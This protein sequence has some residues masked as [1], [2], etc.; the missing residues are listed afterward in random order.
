MPAHLNQ[1]A[2]RAL[3]C[4]A[5]TLAACTSGEK[6]AERSAL[7]QDT[8]SAAAVTQAVTPETAAALDTAPAATPAMEAPAGDVAAGGQE[9]K[10]SGVIAEVTELRRRG[11]AVSAKLRFSNRGSKTAQ[12]EISYK[13]TYLLDPDNNKFEVLK[14]TAG[15][16]L[17]ALRSGYSDRWYDVIESGASQTVWM[18]FSAPPAGVTAVSLQLP[19]VEPFEDLQIAE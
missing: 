10:W 17:A 4:A 16:Y 5:T 8:G 1:T 3:Y 9:T 12:P 13:D 6:A 18:R 14:D 11:N 15:H 2:R 7:K 19:G